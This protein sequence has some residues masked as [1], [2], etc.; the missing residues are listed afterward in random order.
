LQKVMGNHCLA[1]G[2]FNSIKES[3]LTRN[4]GYFLNIIIL[5]Y[6]LKQLV[7]N[8]IPD[9]QAHTITIFS[10][11]ICISLKTSLL[12]SLY[13]PVFLQIKEEKT[14]IQLIEEKIVQKRK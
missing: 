3:G 14:K 7:P 8:N 11:M 12:F 9:C 13:L 2:P 5:S 6:S 1:A 4:I 10:H